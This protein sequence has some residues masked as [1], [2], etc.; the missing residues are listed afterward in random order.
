MCCGIRGGRR[1]VQAG[2]YYHEEFIMRIWLI[3]FAMLYSAML[4]GSFWLW[5]HG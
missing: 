3:I 4:T 1:K 5:V 2:Y